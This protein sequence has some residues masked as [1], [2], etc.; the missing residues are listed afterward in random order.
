LRSDSDGAPVRRQIRKADLLECRKH[1]HLRALHSGEALLQSHAETIIGGGPND[2]ERFIGVPGYWQRL[3]DWQTCERQNRRGDCI[4]DDHTQAVR[5]HDTT[6]RVL[7]WAGSKS[8]P[9]ILAAGL[10]PHSKIEAPEDVTLTHY[11]LNGI[12]NEKGNKLCS[13]SE[14]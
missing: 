6:R 1:T 2:I 9:S 3:R 10:Q 14:R 4:A 13:P 12:L 11:N 7:L 8:P 5:S